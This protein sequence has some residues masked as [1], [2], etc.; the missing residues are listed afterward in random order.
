M[1]IVKELVFN[2]MRD[3]KMTYVYILMYCV[4]LFLEVIVASRLYI[5]FF[6]NNIDKVF[7]KIVRDVCIL[8]ITLY[9]L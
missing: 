9:I 8:W 3:N 6:D 5:K 7:G 1:K 2:F 4:I